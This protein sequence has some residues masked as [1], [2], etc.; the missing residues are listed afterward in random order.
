MGLE[1]QEPVLVAVLE[2]VELQAAALE[3]LLAEAG[4]EQLGELRE[5]RLAAVAALPKLRLPCLRMERQYSHRS[6]SR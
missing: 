1:Q 6:S 2:P 4:V 3:A 5:E